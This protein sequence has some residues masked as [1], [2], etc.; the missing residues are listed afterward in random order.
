[1][2][3]ETLEKL[4]SGTKV[5]VDGYDSNGHRLS[6]FYVY[7]KIVEG[8]MELPFAQVQVG[9]NT[10][11]VAPSA[12]TKIF[13]K[14]KKPKP[15]FA[16]YMWVGPCSN[17]KHRITSSLYEKKH[18]LDNIVLDNDSLYEVFLQEVKK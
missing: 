16:G 10:Y 13:R 15:S 18:S 11:L 1:M 8:A 4:P 17:G 6:N 2:K 3:K 5:F 12:I 14:V 9:S 7:L